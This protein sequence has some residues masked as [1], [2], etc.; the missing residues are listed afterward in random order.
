MVSTAG[1]PYSYDAVDWQAE[2]S[3]P[4][5]YLYF[6]YN[7]GNYAAPQAA[8]DTLK[9]L[10]K[11]IATICISATTVANELDYENGNPDDPVP[12]CQMMRARFKYTGVIYCNE[13]SVQEVLGKFS[14][15]G[16][17]PPYFRLANWTGNPPA[18]L[19]DYGAGTVGIQYTDQGDGGLVDISKVSPNY[20]AIGGSITP[21]PPPPPPVPSSDYQYRAEHNT[22]TPIP[23]TGACRSCWAS[24]LTARR[25][26]RPGALYKR[27]CTR[28]AAACWRRPAAPTRP[29]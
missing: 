15:A 27:C 20:P 22:M 1:W 11:R 13:S 18:Q 7:D 23:A 21:P 6:L 29:R 24:P 26:R 16:V 3:L 8:Y 17:S 28:G 10:G 5:A 2:T 25:G 4:A 12:W 19:P 14:A 9:A